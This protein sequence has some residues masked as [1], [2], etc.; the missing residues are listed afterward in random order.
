MKAKFRVMQIRTIEIDLGLMTV[1]GEPVPGSRRTMTTESG[2][3][4]FR[5]K[6]EAEAF[7]AAIT[8]SHGAEAV[9]PV[10]AN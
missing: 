6:K 4:P 9:G 7:R 2:Y 1:N 5:T 3:H 8:A 10:E